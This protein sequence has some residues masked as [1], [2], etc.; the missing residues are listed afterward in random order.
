VTIY[1]NNN[2]IFFKFMFLFLY[3]VSDQEM[4]DEETRP[5]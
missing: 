1:I 2:I 4:F 5:L 3:A